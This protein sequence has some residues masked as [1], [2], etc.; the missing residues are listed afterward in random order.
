MVASN[1]ALP[2]P[3]VIQDKDTGFYDESV[4]SKAH[5]FRGTTSIAPSEVVGVLAVDF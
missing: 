1:K 5:N 4:V 3:I 2:P